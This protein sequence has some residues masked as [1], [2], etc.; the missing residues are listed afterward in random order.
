MSRATLF[1]YGN[2][3]MNVLE[4]QLLLTGSSNNLQASDSPYFYSSFIVVEIAHRV[5]STFISIAFIGLMISFPY[6]L[7]V[8]VNNVKKCW[9]FALVWSPATALCKE[10]D[11]SKV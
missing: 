7:V 9:D 1:P 5:I 4:V 8:Q 6:L 2:S 11:M 10:L 3:R